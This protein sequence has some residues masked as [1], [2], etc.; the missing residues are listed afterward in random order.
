MCCRPQ[1]ARKKRAAMHLDRDLQ[2][3]GRIGDENPDV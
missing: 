2:L 3:R 1:H